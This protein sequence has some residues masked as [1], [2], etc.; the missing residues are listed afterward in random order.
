MGGYFIWKD[1]LGEGI[2]NKNLGDKN[3]L[4]YSLIYH[5]HT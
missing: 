2:T 5:E 4:G 3:E 1:V